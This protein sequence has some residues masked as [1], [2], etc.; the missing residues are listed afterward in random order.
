[1]SGNW[2][3]E[4][5]PQLLEGLGITL[6]IFVVSVGFGFLLSIPL[7]LA[8]IRGNWMLANL[9]RG[10]CFSFRATPLLMQLFLFY[11]G[12]GALLANS[13]TLREMSPWLMRLDA[14]WYVLIAFT[15]NFAC[16]E[17]EVLRGALLAVPHGE[18]EAG[19][20]FGLS[21]LQILRRLWLPSA[22][23]RA[24][25]V[26]A[27]DVIALLKSTPIAFVVPVVD[28]MA[29]TRN[30]MQNRLLIYEPLLLAGVTYLV[31]SFFVLRLFAVIGTRMPKGWLV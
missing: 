16:H 12:L 7:A 4:F 30:V 25:P 5:A 14:F 11:Y 1:M 17:A 8:Q 27:S 10:F 22:V 29:V 26:F 3:A 20:S 23:L 28:L 24:Y 2:L 6:L 18:I 31:I 9:A 21:R 15:F 13:P 19:E